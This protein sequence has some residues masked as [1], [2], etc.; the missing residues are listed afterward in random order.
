M[1]TC[2]IYDLFDGIGN[3]FK[4]VFKVIEIIIL[5]AIAIGVVVIIYKIVKKAQ[6]TAEANRKTNEYVNNMKMNYNRLDRQSQV[7][8]YRK[9]IE[10]NNHKRNAST[11]DAR[12][13]NS[14]SY[15]N[16]DGVMD[17]LIGAM[18]G[19]M[20][21]D[22]CLKTIKQK[23]GIVVQES[24]IKYDIEYLKKITGL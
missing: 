23:Y 4:G 1:I 9:L 17:G 8:I 21:A 5:I 6:A 22:D 2:T 11:S 13:K 7:E 14:A 19:H 18:A 12:A 20:L 16:K 3:F 15:G 24:Y 10:Y